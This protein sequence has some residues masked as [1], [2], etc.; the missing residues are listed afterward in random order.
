MFQSYGIS[1]ARA[2]SDPLASVRMKAQRDHLYTE[3]AMLE[4]ELDTFQSSRLAKP[5]RERPRLTPEQRAQI[6]QL[7]SLRQ[8][9]TK[10]IAD[11]LGLHANTINTWKKA[12]LNKNRTEE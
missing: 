5:P 7:A 8:W 2:L 1:K 12:L 6:T 4:R 10:Q 9:S 3:S 11:R